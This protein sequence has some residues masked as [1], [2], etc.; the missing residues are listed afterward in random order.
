MVDGEL[1]FVHISDSHIGTSED[2]TLYNKRPAEA[3]RNL[4]SYLNDELPFAPDFVLHTGD[5]TY[6]P[7]PLA[8]PLA[9]EILGKL[10]Y[11]SYYARGNHDNPDAMRQYLPNLP[12]G[13]GRVDYSFEVNGFHFVVLDSFGLVQ[14]A[15]YLE[16][17][18]LEWLHET[19]RESKARSLVIVI[20]HLPTVTGNAW[21]DARMGIVNH[22]DFFAVLAPFAHKIRGV[23]FGHIHTGS[24]VMREGIM[25]SSV[26]ATFSQFI[27]PLESDANLMLVPLGGFNLVTLTHEQTWVSQHQLVLKGG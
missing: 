13:S 10:K 14:P 16:V 19:C 12:A 24:T 22:E 8:Y 4:V 9:A 23:F 17:G 25:C 7:D 15:G 20:H 21:L 6:D 2:Y 18:Q 26:A 5:V 11:P 1:R 27:Y 3:L